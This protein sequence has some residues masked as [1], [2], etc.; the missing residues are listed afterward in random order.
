MEAPKLW[1]YNFNMPKGDINLS[2]LTNCLS[3]TFLNHDIKAF[4][5]NKNGNCATNRLNFKKCNSD[6][7]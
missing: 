1:N 5:D 6:T 4:S 2:L 7:K 3:V